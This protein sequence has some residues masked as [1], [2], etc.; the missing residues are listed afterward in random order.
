[1]PLERFA[2]TEVFDDPWY[3]G[4]LRVTQ[5]LIEQDG[6]TMLTMTLLYESREAR[7]G[8]LKTPMKQGVAAGYDRLA[9]LLASLS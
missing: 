5:A 4:E 8:V 6:T 7:D 2:N 1:M 3:P 9:E